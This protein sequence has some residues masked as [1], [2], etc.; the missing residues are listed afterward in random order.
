M[1]VMYST[2]C[3]RCKILQDKLAKINETVTMIYGEEE[4]EKLGYTSAPL[5]EVDGTMMD[6]GQAVRWVNKIIKSNNE[7]TEM[8]HCESCNI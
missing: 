1:I 4:I 2:G 6:F 5:L 3:P 8:T 7:A